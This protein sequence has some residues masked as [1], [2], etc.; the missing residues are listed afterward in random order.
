MTPPRYTPLRHVRFRFPSSGQ[1]FVYQALGSAAEPRQELHRHGL[2]GGADD[3][4]YR[5]VWPP[6]IEDLVTQVQQDAF[7]RQA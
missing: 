5:T 4:G 3:G 6:A 7:T 1:H 2:L